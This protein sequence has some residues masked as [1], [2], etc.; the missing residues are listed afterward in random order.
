MAAAG[1]PAGVR[2]RSTRPP[3]P[4]P[5]PAPPAR[6]LPVLLLLAAGWGGGGSGRL[7]EGRRMH[8]LKADCELGK[9]LAKG[10]QSEDCTEFVFTEAV[11]TQI[12]CASSTQ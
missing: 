2:D 12:S 6:P 4:A 11:E 5:A 10:R 8:C 9:V 3:P 1:D 7:F